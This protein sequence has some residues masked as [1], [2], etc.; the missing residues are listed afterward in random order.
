MNQAENSKENPSDPIPELPTQKP[1]QLSDS[2]E[3]E[4][5]VNQAPDQLVENKDPLQGQIEP[6]QEVEDQF[7]PEINQEHQASEQLQAALFSLDTTSNQVMDGAEPFFF[8][9]G[10]T[11]CL[12]VHGFTGTPKEM[13]WLG[14]YLAAQGHTVLGVRLFAHATQPEDMK[15]A[16][17]NDWLT[18]VEDGWHLLKGSCKQIVVIGLSM[19][20]ILSLLFA[21]KHPLAG[22]VAMSTPHHLPSDLRLNFIKPIS[23]FMPYMKKD[24]PT[25]FDQAALEQHACY[26]VDP[27]RSY[28][29]LRDMLK[30]MRQNLAYVQSPALL[31]YS[32]NDPVVTPGERHMEKIFQELG[33]LEKQT[34]W[35]EKSG[36]VVVRDAQRDQVFLAVANF[37]D[38][39]TIKSR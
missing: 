5:S 14:E 24:E 11:G 36:H 21:S 34:L 17:W 30:V 29:E 8:P 35:I 39:I 27:T 13:R 22:V 4:G 31:I 12:L 23:L 6:K 25:W 26:P 3:I 32:K 18:D 9:G 37:I 15:R 38:R 28:A 20:G 19:G 33:S 10:P 16:R 1:T 2:Q 7:Q